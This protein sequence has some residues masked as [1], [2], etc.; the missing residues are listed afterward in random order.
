[1]NRALISI[2]LLM[3]TGCWAKQSASKSS[4]GDKNNNANQIAVSTAASNS[5]E[6][7][8]DFSQASEASSGADQQSGE[9]AAELAQ[10]LREANRSFTYKGKP[11]NPR[12]VNELLVWI[13]DGVD[14]PGPVAVDLNG[15]NDTN[16]YYG[17]Y[18]KDKDGSIT[19]DSKNISPKR[20]DQQEG[21]FSYNRL[22]T[23]Q[24]GIHVLETWENSGGTGVF[25]NLLLV[26][27]STDFEYRQNGSRRY[28]L[29]MQRMGEIPLGDRNGGQVA[30]QA[31]S[32]TIRIG[33][34]AY[35]N[36]E[37]IPGKVITIK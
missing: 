15:T 5:N 16:R 4:E 33:P 1:M 9:R 20:E 30:I 3:L 19:I 27:F 13:S 2:L 8:E 18:N 7:L 23:L 21:Y 6:A 34:G 35:P 28:R 29:L 32:N 14:E 10:Q 26:K 31:S 12:A 37:K 36:G 24:N 17:A 25:T 11:I 22:G